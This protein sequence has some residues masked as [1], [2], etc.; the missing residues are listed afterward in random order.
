MLWSSSD[1]CDTDTICEADDFFE[2]D[3]AFALLVHRTMRSQYANTV[4]L[5]VLQVTDPR[6]GPLRPK[7]ALWLSWPVDTISF[8]RLPI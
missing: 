3:A 8:G 2:A 7:A 6:H 5:N 1:A 4:G